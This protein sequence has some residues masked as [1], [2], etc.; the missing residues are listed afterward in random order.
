[1]AYPVQMVLQVLRL[2][3]FNLV[4]CYY[5]ILDSFLISKGIHY[6]MRGL[7]FLF[8]F[9]NL[10]FLIF[11]K[12]HFLCGLKSILWIFIRYMLCYLFVR[13]WIILDDCSYGCEFRFSFGWVRNLLFLYIFC[14]IFIFYGDC[15][16]IRNFLNSSILVIKFYYFFI[17]RSHIND[18]SIIKYRLTSI[19]FHGYY[20]WSTYS[21]LYQI[22]SDIL[23]NFFIIIRENSKSY[24]SK[25]QYY[26]FHANNG[27]HDMAAIKQIDKKS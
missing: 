17:I 2:F 23:H 14:L 24:H 26:Y 21:S 25:L 10:L 6:L 3:N 16:S 13:F 12:L 19:L 8:N 7:F 27:P 11:F 4:L 5:L 22:S 1:M 20:R 9:I 15:C 18:Q